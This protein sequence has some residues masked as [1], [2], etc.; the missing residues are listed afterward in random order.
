MQRRGVVTRGIEV[1]TDSIQEWE[2]HI[3]RFPQDLGP[4]P[5]SELPAKLGAGKDEDGEPD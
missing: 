1:S 2:G 3:I 5:R 4:G